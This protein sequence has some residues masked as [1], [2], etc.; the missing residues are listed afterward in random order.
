MTKAVPP[1][2]SPGQVDQAKRGTA[3]SVSLSGVTVRYGRTTVLD[4]LDL[5]IEHGEFVALLGPSGSGKTTVIRTIAGFIRPAHGS[6]RLAD[7]EVTHLPPNKRNVGVVFQ[8][9]AL[10]PHMSVNDNLAYPL[11]AKKVKRDVI[12]KRCKD[13]LEL[14]QLP[15]VGEVRPGRLSGGQQQRVALARALAMEPELLLLDEPLSNLDANLRVDV[16]AEI[17]RLQQET[18]TTAIMVTHDRRE[19]FAMADRIAVLRSG[20][21]E[22][23][24]APA[25]IYRRP[26]SRFMAEFVGD[27]NFVDGTVQSCDEQGTTVLTSLGPLVVPGAAS[28]G[29]RVDVLLRPEDL[30][31]IGEPVPAAGPGELNITA[32]VTRVSYFGSSI[33]MDVM[34]GD[35]PLSVVATGS[36]LDVPDVGGTVTVR[37]R[38]T[39]CVLVPTGVQP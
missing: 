23:L 2:P 7:A 19:A 21:I 8:S 5:D 14:V 6:V 24:G 32:R 17:R 33:A 37:A 27:A 36:V 35:H 25:E 29:A 4:A 10:F 30:R 3:T 28:V 12:A 26:N 13:L 16:G 34:A 18:G 11:K 39:D 1:M 31:L 15:D 22:Q 20:R 38:T 9:Y